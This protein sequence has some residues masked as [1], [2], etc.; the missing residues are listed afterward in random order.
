M[1]VVIVK[2][3]SS[4]TVCSNS[5]DLDDR[6]ALGGFDLPG[7]GGGGNISRGIFATWSMYF[8]VRVRL[9]RQLLMTTS[10]KKGCFG[11][12]AASVLEAPIGPAIPAA[13]LGS[14]R[15]RPVFSRFF[16]KEL[17]S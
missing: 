12:M 5:W 7:R 14:L 10:G 13:A 9:R 3:T 2:D 17:S 15:N 8:V 16:A 4:E 11:K 6:L 1:L